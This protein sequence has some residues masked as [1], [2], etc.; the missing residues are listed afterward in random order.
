MSL[1]LSVKADGRSEQTLVTIFQR[2]GADGLSMVAPVE[3]DL[4]YRARP[5][6]G[7]PKKDAIKLDG[8]FGMTPLLRDL[9]PAWQ[10]G[11]LA[12]IHGAGSEDQSRSHFEAQDVMEHGGLAAGGWLGRYLRARPTA[13]AGAL[14]CVAVGRLL[15]E[16]LL[17][18][19][20][21]AVMEKLEDFS[22][23]AGGPAM[24]AE[25]QRLYAGETDRLGSSARDTFDALGRIDAMRQQKYQPEHGAVYGT[26]DFALGLQ[27]IARLIKA[28]VGLEA[29]SL[30][31]GG[32]DAHFTSETVHAALLP[33]MG[34]ALAAFRRDMGPAMASTTLVVMTEF[35]R[36]VTENSSFGTDHGRGGVMWVMGGGVRGGRVIGPWRGLSSEH[37]DGPGDVPVTNNYRDVLAPILV[38]HGL[39]EEQLPRVFPDFKLQ[40]LELYS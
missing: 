28:R 26:D 9:E 25:L 10:E 35:G 24:R 5:R 39:P 6:L 7:I 8:V 27:Q 21:V 16:S 36:R 11:D 40:P 37:L 13:G 29:A 17:G 32:W 34:R 20:S 18:A 12:V 30:D 1:Q 2:G 23:G 33:Q 4:Y 14:T 31:L 19:P 22:F 38:R 3:D 15:P